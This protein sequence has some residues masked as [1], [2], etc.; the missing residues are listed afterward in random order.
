MGDT[1]KWRF[2]IE[3]ADSGEP[4]EISANGIEMD[5]RRE[6]EA[7]QPFTEWVLTLADAETRGR[8]RNGC[9]P[10]RYFVD[11]VDEDGNIVETREAFLVSAGLVPSSDSASRELSI[12]AAY[13]VRAVAPCDRWDVA[14]VLSSADGNEI[15]YG[16][17]QNMLIDL[18]RLAERHGLIL[19]RSQ[20]IGGSR[21]RED[22][23]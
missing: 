20:V 9:L 11:R 17:L 5:V 1:S 3:D 6:G 19:V 4:I 14:I 8:L 7:A 15:S 21:G 16:A 23:G 22:G 10:P 12:S 2:V 13:E 18:A